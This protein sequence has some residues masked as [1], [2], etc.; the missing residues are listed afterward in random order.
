MI[1]REQNRKITW[2]AV[3]HCV[4]R[5]NGFFFVFPFN[6]HHRYAAIDS[7]AGGGKRGR[8][9]SEDVIGKT[10]SRRQKRGSV[11]YCMLRC[12]T[13]KD[14]QSGDERGWKWK[15]KGVFFSLWVQKKTM[16]C[17]RKGVRSEMRL[18]GKKK[19]PCLWWRIHRVEMIMCS[20]FANLVILCK[21]S[22]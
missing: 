21:Q 20:N 8:P 1:V 6:S 4:S 15:G 22:F 2:S 19:M 14:R 5:D 9:K 13:H 18:V 12:G 3:K 11:F 10:S 17:K 7:L 16:S